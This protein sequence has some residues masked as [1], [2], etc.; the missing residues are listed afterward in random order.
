M[1]AYEDP[2][3]ILVL[4]QVSF[5]ARQILR[6][7]ILASVCIPCRTNVTI[8]DKQNGGNIQLDAVRQHH[9]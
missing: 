7:N 9:T 5:V 8:N 2:E 6:L 4:E 1:P 3:Q